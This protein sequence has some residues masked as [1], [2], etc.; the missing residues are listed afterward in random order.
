MIDFLKRIGTVFATI[1]VVVALLLVS[2]T[3]LPINLILFYIFGWIL[4]LFS[5]NIRQTRL[6]DS[7]A[8]DAL[9]VVDGIALF[10]FVMVVFRTFLSSNLL[11][12]A[13]GLAGVGAVLY[14]TS[15]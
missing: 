10:V 8:S 2:T 3:Y 7:I 15:L 5:L 12:M 9:T 14:S 1:A 4:A 11:G 6:R 13:L